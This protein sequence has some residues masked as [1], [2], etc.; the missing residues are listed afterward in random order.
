MRI[1]K[2]V[3]EEAIEACLCCADDRMHGLMSLTSDHAVG[4]PDDLADAAWCAVQPLVDYHETPTGS[5]RY[6]EAAALLR[7]DD[8]HK[9]WSPGDPVYLLNN[10]AGRAGRE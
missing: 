2:R 7:G 8:E 10:A 1:S 9:P 6:L 3:R 5:A 4:A